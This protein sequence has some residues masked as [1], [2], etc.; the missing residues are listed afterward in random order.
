[1][2][3]EMMPNV[4]N[5]TLAVTPNPNALDFSICHLRSVKEPVICLYHWK[6][7]LIP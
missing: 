1:M 4:K 6:V 2:R 5:M 3:Y 7:V